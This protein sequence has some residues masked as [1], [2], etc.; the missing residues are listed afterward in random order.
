MTNSTKTKTVAVRLMHNTTLTRTRWCV[1][2][3]WEPANEIPGAEFI[4][5][6]YCDDQEEVAGIVCFADGCEGD[7]V[8]VELDD[9]RIASCGCKVLEDVKL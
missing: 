4:D 2:V 8:E 5:G 3:G 6:S 1:P 7:E 9:L